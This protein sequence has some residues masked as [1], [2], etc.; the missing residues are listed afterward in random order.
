MQFPG[1]V[2]CRWP[3]LPPCCM[4]FQN[5][6]RSRR[7]FL[8]L[9]W[10]FPRGSAGASRVFSAF[11]SCCCGVRVFFELQPYAATESAVAQE[12]V[13]NTLRRP[14]RENNII[15][16][17]FGTIKP[18][19]KNWIQCKKGDSKIWCYLWMGSVPERGNPAASQLLWTSAASTWHSFSTPNP[20]LLTVL[21]P[22]F[23]STYEK[24]RPR[25]FSL[26]KDILFALSIS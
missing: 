3:I 6:H 10:G 7:V 26:C 1:A 22:S 18:K 20:Y 25:L 11:D 5:T 9:V 24:R 15:L 21:K 14:M 19:P 23:I 13:F 16:I 8:V 17:R 2:L 4:V 12:S